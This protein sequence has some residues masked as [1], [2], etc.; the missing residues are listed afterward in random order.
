M[1]IYIHIHIYICI[2][3]DRYIFI[4]IILM[5]YYLA[6]YIY[7]YGSLIQ[8]YINLSY[9]S[10]Y[11]FMGL[12]KCTMINIYLLMCIFIQIHVHIYNDT[13]ICYFHWVMLWLV[14]IRIYINIDINRFI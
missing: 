12:H 9:T 6:L 8:K 11:I 10:N 7:F 14:A 4:H 5:Q 2:Y 3:R 1:N 13:N